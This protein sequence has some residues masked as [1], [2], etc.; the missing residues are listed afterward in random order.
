ML[1]IWATP[2]SIIAQSANDEYTTFDD[3]NDNTDPARKDS[4]YSDAMTQ[5]RDSAIVMPESFNTELDALLSG[6]FHRHFVHTNINCVS[7]ADVPNVPDSVYIARLRALPTIIDMPFNQV[8][9]SYLDMYVHRRRSLVE[10]MVGLSDFYFPIFEEAL[11]RYNMPME[12]KYLPV[13]ES[14]LK[15][16][17]TSRV[18]AAGLWQFMP[19]TGRKMGLE[20]NSVIDERRDPVKSTDAACRYLL[21]LYTMYNDWTL[22]IAAYNCGPGNVNKAI[23]RSGGKMNFWDIY[24][25]LPRETRGYI[26]AFIAANYIMT[27]HCEHNLCAVLTELPPL[28]DTIMTRRTVHF[29]Q[30]S[31]ILNLPIEHIRALNPQYGYDLVPG[32]YKPCALRLPVQNLYEYIEREDSILA[33]KA[34]SLLPKNGD[35]QTLIRQGRNGTFYANGATYHTVKKG[36]TLSKI[37]RKYHTSVKRIKQLNNMKSDRLTVKKRLRV[38]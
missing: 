22:A 1:C 31:A 4:A 24:F 34:D 29:R 8:V 37:A 15:P 26:P 2:I 7:D 30:I 32:L 11:S 38:R 13:I 14:A 19:S 9:R 17:A 10:Y 12:L 6:W 23:K 28:S 35:I 36:D 25:Y 3:E 16:T 20:I 21:E 27:Y 33:Y 18:G 5:I